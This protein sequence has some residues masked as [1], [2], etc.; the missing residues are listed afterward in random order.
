MNIFY[1]P[2]IASVRELPEEESHHCI[3]VLRQVEGDEL[4][5]ADGAG[6]FYRAV[7]VSAH[8]KHCAVDIVETI[9]APP[10]WGFRLH[11]AI[12]PTKNLDRMEWF[13]EKCTEIGIDAITPL[14]CRYSERREMKG[15][16]LH[17]IVISA[18]KQSL[19]AVCPQ[20]DEMTDFDRFVRQ[21]FSG[22]KFIAHCQEGE[23]V[24]LAQ[25]YEAGRDA[26]VLIGPEGDFSRDEIALAT[27]CGFRA[28]SLGDSRLR[29]ETAGVVAC[30][31]L[32]II[33]QIN[34]KK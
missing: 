2:D 13:A 11:V 33:N 5:L 21:S 28:V 31:T 22:D 20:L 34:R 29:T 12:A 15:D 4:M 7:I 6:T 26:L 18:M 30:H 14:R 9:P 8:P 32:H 10:A 3:K 24:P 16:R 23:R 27:D 19:K 17:K 25:L 1:T